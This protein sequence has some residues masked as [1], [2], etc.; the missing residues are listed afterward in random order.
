MVDPMLPHQQMREQQNMASQ[1]ETAL[2]ESWFGVGLIPFEVYNMLQSIT[3]YVC[4]LMQKLS[5]VYSIHVYIH[6]C[7]CVFVVRSLMVIWV[8]RVISL[9]S[10]YP[11]WS[12]RTRS[13]SCFYLLLVSTLRVHRI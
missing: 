5:I 12:Y 10:I 9:V 4:S 11:S 2:Q 7:I 3:M 8:R 13:V 1:I 6:T